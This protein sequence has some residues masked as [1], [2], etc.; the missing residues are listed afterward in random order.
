MTAF[1]QLFRAH[2][3]P[4]LARACHAHA[5]RIVCGLETWVGAYA[6]VMDA[7]RQRGA[8]HLPDHLLA[9][10]EDWAATQLLTEIERAEAVATPIRAAVEEATEWNRRLEIWAA[11]QEA[12]LCPTTSLR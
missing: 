5:T 1:P 2:V 12:A 11:A 9:G 7:A 3:T 8:T 10:L 4:D 6:A